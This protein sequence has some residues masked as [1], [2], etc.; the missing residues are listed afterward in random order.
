MLKIWKM[1]AD[2]QNVYR[3]NVSLCSSVVLVDVSERNSNP[4][5][6][7]EFTFCGRYL[8]FSFTRMIRD[9]GVLP[10]ELHRGK[11]CGCWLLVSRTKCGC[12][13]SLKK[14]LLPSSPKKTNFLSPPIKCLA[15]QEVQPPCFL[16]TWYEPRPRPTGIWKFR[17]NDTIQSISFP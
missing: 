10:S 15:R 7:K 9:S 16:L 4:G 12:C 13:S 14:K 6:E 11:K 17:S 3:Y 8:C 5:G 1:A 2:F